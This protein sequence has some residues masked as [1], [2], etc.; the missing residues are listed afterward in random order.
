MTKNLAYDET[1]VPVAQSQE[2]LKRLLLKNRASGMAFVSQPP[3]EGFQAQIVIDEKTYTIRVQCLARPMKHE[4]QQRQEERRVWRVLFFHM[5]ALFE[6]A[7]SGLMEFRE[8][9]L[10][11]IVTRSGQTIAEHIL[12]QLEAAVQGNPERLLPAPKKT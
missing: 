11:Y 9:I 12:P 6:A 7:N 5:K 2:E 8:L 10:P 3:M 1:R 4:D